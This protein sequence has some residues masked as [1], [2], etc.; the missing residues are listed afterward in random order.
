M[1]VLLL[2]CLHDNTTVI[3]YYKENRYRSKDGAL[4][5]LFHGGK[6]IALNEIHLHL[7]FLYFFFHLGPVYTDPGKFWH[8]RILFLDRLFTWI[9][10]NSV[11]QG[12]QW[13]LH[14]SVQSL[15]QLRFLIPGH[16]CAI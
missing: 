9:R 6:E 1:K 8:G 12:L 10:A 4:K 14:G 11:A 13:C 3:N 16:N 7:G 15:D 5:Y 2:T